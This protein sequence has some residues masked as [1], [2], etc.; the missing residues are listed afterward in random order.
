MVPRSADGVGGLRDN[1]RMAISSERLAQTLIELAQELH[2][3]GIP[4]AIAGAYAVALHGHPRATRDI[5]VLTRADVR[6]QVAVVMERLGYAEVSR[7]DGFASYERVPLPELPGIVE[8]TDFLFSSRAL[9][10][11]ALAHAAST[12][13]MW[14][15]V[16]LPVVPVDA[17][18]L[19]KLMALS[20]DARR[21]NDLADA[22]ALL[23]S[24]RAALDLSGLRRDADE[25]GPDVRARLESLLDESSVAEHEQTYGA[26]R[27]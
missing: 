17:L 20:N 4:F 27:I 26:L 2:R 14:R 11:R 10:A 16:P 13:V 21:P 9:G 22:R 6:A 8:R 1:G 7:G 5:D 12:P 18:I 19:M 24:H 15:D 23:R 25:V 3:V